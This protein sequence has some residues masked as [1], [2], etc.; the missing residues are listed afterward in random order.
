MNM[1]TEI[2][3]AVTAPT[4]DRRGFLTFAAK[5]LAIAFTM[6][7]VGRVAAV[8]AATPSGPTNE[9]LAT[10][11]INIGTD[12]SIT[13]NFGGAEMGQGSMTGLS[14]I[15]AEE[16]MVDWNQITVKQS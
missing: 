10:A 14:Q 2:L 3:N 1:P 6:P 11:Y 16:L 8:Q 13:L 12:G 5:G 4:M 9:Q 7:V 15:L